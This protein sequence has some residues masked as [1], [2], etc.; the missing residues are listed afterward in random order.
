MMMMM[1]CN[2]VTGKKNHFPMLQGFPEDLNTKLISNSTI[3]L[4]ARKLELVRLNQ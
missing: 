3:S 1:G 4:F 2:K